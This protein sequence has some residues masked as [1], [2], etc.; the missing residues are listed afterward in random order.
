MIIGLSGVPA[1]GKDTVA[2]YLERNK[3]FTHISL[4]AILREIVISRNLE[5]NLHN[6]TEVGNSLIGEF[7]EGYLV[8][9]A[10]K[11][12][13]QN[14]N[15]VISS[16]RQPG[17][18]TQL[19]KQNDF[20]MVFVDADPKIRFERLKLRGR[21]GDSE[22]FEDFINIEKKQLDGKSG[23]MNLGKCKEMSDIV[24]ENNGSIAEFSQKIENII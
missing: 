24:I 6:L 1:A 10:L 22:T 20:I 23:A 15:A 9:E 14:E 13:D 7:G 16:I 21:A 17:E 3:N 8:K 4:S 19:Q 11:R 18:I 5:L 2:E 12:I